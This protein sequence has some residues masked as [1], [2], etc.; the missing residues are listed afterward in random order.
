M[1]RNQEIPV[2]F[3]IKTHIILFLEPW[4][5]HRSKIESTHNDTSNKWLELQEYISNNYKDKELDE[6]SFRINH[7]ERELGSSIKDR[8]G[9]RTIHVPYQDEIDKPDESEASV[10]KSESGCNSRSG[11]KPDCRSAHKSCSKS[12]TNSGEYCDHDDS[13][14]TLSPTLF[15]SKPPIYKKAQSPRSERSVSQ[16]DRETPQYNFYTN[17]R[18]ESEHD[19]V[20]EN[21][22]V[23]AER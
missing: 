2:C 20:E 13:Q 18:E 17:S 11:N 8:D 12:G 16:R 6:H 3:V 23:V 4:H 21:L 7:Q 22:H 9:F 10:C 5:V 1:M 15:C 19:P 14:R